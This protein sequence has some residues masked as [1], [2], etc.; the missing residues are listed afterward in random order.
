MAASK[1]SLVNAKQHDQQ[2]TAQVLWPC[3]RRA[4]RAWHCASA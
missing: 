1:I 2:L 4:R 3:H